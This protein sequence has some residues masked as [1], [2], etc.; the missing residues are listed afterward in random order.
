MNFFD[1]SVSPD[2]RRIELPA[3]VSLPL[4]AGQRVRENVREVILGFR[5]EHL[6]PAESEGAPL[7]LHVDHVELLGADTLVHGHL[8]DIKNTVTARI[9]WVQHFAKGTI[10]PL[11]IAPESLHLFDP[12]NRTRVGLV[13]A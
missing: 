1:A 12:E 3:G 4:P 9:P 10:L 2:G 11:T 5:P 6:R 7:P 8:S 13:P